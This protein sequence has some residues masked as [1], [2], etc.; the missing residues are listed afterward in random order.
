MCV[1]GQVIGAVKE[2]TRRAFLAGPRRL[3]EA[4]FDCDVQ[5]SSDMLGRCAGL[6]V[7]GLRVEG[8]GLRVEG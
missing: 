5:T 4:V 7:R 1:S 3:V 2:G 6:G 8:L